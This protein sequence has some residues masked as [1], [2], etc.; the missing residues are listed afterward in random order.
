MP[1]V[2]SVGAGFQQTALCGGERNEWRH[3]S[4]KRAMEANH[5]VARRAVVDLPQR[6]DDSPRAGAQKRRSDADGALSRV[7]S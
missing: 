1:R 4:G 7:C 5:Q 3:P 2:V 6:S